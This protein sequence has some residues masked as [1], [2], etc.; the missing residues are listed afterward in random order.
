MSDD[1]REL[2]TK[3]GSETSLRY[4]IQLIMAAAI[5][6]Q[7]RKVRCTRSW[8]QGPPGG[9]QPA[10]HGSSHLCGAGCTS[11]CVRGGLEG[12]RRGNSGIPSHP[13][14]PCSPCHNG[15]RKWGAGTSGACTRP[16]WGCQILTPPVLHALPSLLPSCPRHVAMQA[17]QVEIEDISRVYTLFV[18]VK[19]STQ[20]LMEYQEQYMFNEVPGA[21][22]EEEGGGGEG[23]QAM[24]S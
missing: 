13:L 18:D 19:R 12:A 24:S 4:S 15:R 11:V 10:H 5:C 21:D 17:A 6:A 2:L 22:E 23:Q 16:L 3:I 9:Q 20:F 1:A 8:L 14:L 7:R